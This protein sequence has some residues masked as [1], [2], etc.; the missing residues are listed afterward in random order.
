[1]SAALRFKNTD[2]TTVITTLSLGNIASPGASSNHK[3]Y[4]ENYGD[5]TAQSVT[6][7]LETVGSSDGITYALEATDVAGS[8]GAFGA[9]PLSVGDIAAGIKVA[10]WT[11]ASLVSGLTADQNPRRYDIQADG[12]SV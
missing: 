4:V 8:P 7:T 2:G 12:T 3:L 10:F 11:R 6:M 5:A 1:M 9:G